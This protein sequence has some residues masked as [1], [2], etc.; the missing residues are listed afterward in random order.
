[1]LSWKNEPKSSW[2]VVELTWHFAA[3][4]C[5]DRWLL[6]TGR[7]KISEAAESLWAVVLMC[8]RWSP[9]TRDTFKIWPRVTKAITWSISSLCHRAAIYYSS[10]GRQNCDSNLRP[11]V[12]MSVPLKLK[13]DCRFQFASAVIYLWWCPP[14]LGLPHASIIFA[15]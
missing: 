9:W 12:T 10:N 1:M 6:Q 3:Q 13:E 11:N 8:G 2:K 7:G 14:V 5:I 15:K 4:W